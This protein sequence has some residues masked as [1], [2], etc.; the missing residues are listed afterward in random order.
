MPEWLGSAASRR[1]RFQFGAGAAVVLCVDSFWARY[2]T[3]GKLLSVWSSGAP[4]ERREESRFTR[5]RSAI[6][7]PDGPVEIATV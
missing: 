6:D 5:P 2:L 4:P 7:T 1:L 3:S